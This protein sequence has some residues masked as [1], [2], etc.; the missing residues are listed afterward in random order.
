MQL[1][2]RGRYRQLCEHAEDWLLVRVRTQQKVVVSNEITRY[3]TAMLPVPTTAARHNT[4]RRWCWIRRLCKPPPHVQPMALDERLRIACPRRN[5]KNRP[6]IHCAVHSIQKS[7]SRVNTC[8]SAATPTPALAYSDT[9]FSKKL[10]LPCNEMRV[11]Q[12]NGLV[13]L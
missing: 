7:A 3:T 5:T 11:I 4:A 2:L 6:H 8:S 1:L 13:T 10:V 12:S 9:R